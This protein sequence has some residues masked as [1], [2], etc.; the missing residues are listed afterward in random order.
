MKQAIIPL[1]L[2]LAE[3]QALASP[4]PGRIRLEACLNDPQNASTSGQTDCEGAA[5]RAYDRRMNFAY[6]TLMKRLPL[7]AREKLRLAQRSWILFRN[8]ERSARIGIFETRQG[9]MYV[10][11][12]AEQETILVRDRAL[13]LEAYVRV[14]NIAP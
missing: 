12:A 11:I 2:F 10:P 8:T 6:F 13:Q 7:T 3:A 14:L 9:T 5:L 4:D 1:V